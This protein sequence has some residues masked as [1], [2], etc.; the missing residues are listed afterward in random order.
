LALET[1]TSVKRFSLEGCAFTVKEKIALSVL[2]EAFLAVTV[3]R[4]RALTSVGANLTNTTGADQI[5]VIGSA[6]TGI[7]FHNSGG[8]IASCTVAPTLPAGLSM[9]LRAAKALAVE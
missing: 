3:Y 4:V 1:S 7:T 2:S 8:S 5:V 6:I 9:V